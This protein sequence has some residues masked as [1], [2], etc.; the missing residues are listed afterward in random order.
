MPRGHCLTTK[1]HLFVPWVQLFVLTLKL[2]L[3]L[4]LTFFLS[5]QR[6]RIRIK[7]IEFIGTVIN[8]YNFIVQS[9]HPTYY[10][11]ILN[12]IPDTR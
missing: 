10:I 7:D 3:H 6:L 11:W 2:N 5:A 9:M 8:Q 4:I 12:V 1:G